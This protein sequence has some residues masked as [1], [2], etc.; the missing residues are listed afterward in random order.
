MAEGDYKFCVSHRD[1]YFLRYRFRIECLY[2][3]LYAG[4]GI[5]V[6]RHH[7]ATGCGF[8]YHHNETGQR[9]EISG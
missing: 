5:F 8:G 7:L 2:P 4:I 9:A 6:R 3:G 1:H